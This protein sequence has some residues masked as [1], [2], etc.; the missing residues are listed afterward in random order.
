[1]SQGIGLHRFIL[2]RDAMED[3][4]HELWRILCE[5]AAVEQD[6]NRLL[7][8]VTRVNDLLEQQEKRL[9]GR[10]VKIGNRTILAPEEQISWWPV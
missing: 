4:T 2:W 8:L 10:P 3:E 9:I 6:P 7:E 1:M 5:Q